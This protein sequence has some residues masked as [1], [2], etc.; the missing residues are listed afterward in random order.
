MSQKAKASFI[1]KIKCP[2]PDHEDHKPSCAFYSDGS[3]YC[4]VCNLYFPSAE[5]YVPV[6]TDVVIE[7]LNEKLVYIDALP[8]EIIR[9]IRFPIDQSGYF[10]KWPEND[11]YKLRKWDSSDNAS[12]YYCPKGHSKPLYVIPGKAQTRELVIVEGEINAI[13]LSFINNTFDI[14]SPGG[15]GNFTD[16]EMIKELNKLTYYDTILICVDSDTAGLQG[17]LKLKSLIYKLPLSTEVIIHLMEKDFNQLLVEHG[18][19]FKESVKKEFES[20]GLPSWVQ[21]G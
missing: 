9:G 11:Y 13:S 14:I 5:D 18:E 19:N 8:T 2:N 10:I 15:V 7:D 12:K 6:L 3:A 17:A 4:F 21:N 1:K 20:V 16:N